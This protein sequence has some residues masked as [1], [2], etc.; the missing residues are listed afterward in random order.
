MKVKLLHSK[1]SP[2]QNLLLLIILLLSVNFT[3][4]TVS[5]C[6]EIESIEFSNGDSNLDIIDGE[7]YYLG[8]LPND[9][10]INTNV[11]GNIQSV[12]YVVKNL[13]TDQQFS[14][15]ENYEP[16]TFP[17]GNAAW[18]LGEGTYRIKVRVY[19]YNYGLGSS[20]DKRNL[21]ITLTNECAANA[22]S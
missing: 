8:D 9:F 13:D 19:K 20:C 3:N 2:F 21:T 7:S 4:A 22:G 10:Y 11:S 14:I 18:N 17:A 16:Y 15:V 5:N 12:R 1:T 6:G